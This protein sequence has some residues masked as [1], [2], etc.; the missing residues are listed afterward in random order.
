MSASDSR[1]HSV[2]LW[3]TTHSEMAHRQSSYAGA[4]IDWSGM[5]A[6][7]A[8]LWSELQYATGQRIAARRRDVAVCCAPGSR[9]SHWLTHP[10]IAVEAMQGA[11]AGRPGAP[12]RWSPTREPWNLAKSPIMVCCPEWI[13]IEVLTLARCR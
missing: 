5:P 3:R 8:S 9:Y 13:W 1:R 12:K 6:A 7:S 4:T 11:S 2:S 10:G